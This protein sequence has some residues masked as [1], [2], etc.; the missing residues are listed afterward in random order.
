MKYLPLRRFKHGTIMQTGAICKKILV[1]CATQLA[2]GLL[3]K[4][5]RNLSKIRPLDFKKKM[6]AQ[7]QKMFCKIPINT[8]ATI[9]VMILSPLFDFEG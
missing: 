4:E 3:L 6:I 8:R 1:I 7:L 9:S 5:T 2:G